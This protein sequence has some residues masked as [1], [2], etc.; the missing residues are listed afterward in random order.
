MDSLYTN[1]SQ[2]IIALVEVCIL[3]SYYCT[4]SDCPEIA[5]IVTAAGKKLL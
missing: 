4:Q 3:H 2:I 5:I 1:I